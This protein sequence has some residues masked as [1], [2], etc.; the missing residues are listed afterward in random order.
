VNGIDVVTP[1]SPDISR[2]ECTHIQGIRAEDVVGYLNAL[3]TKKMGA[4]GSPEGLE[5]RA[6]SCELHLVFLKYLNISS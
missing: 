3:I 5:K 2:V 6:G 1:D 4:L